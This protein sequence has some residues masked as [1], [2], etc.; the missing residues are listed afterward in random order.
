M[1]FGQGDLCSCFHKI[2]TGEKKKKK[3]TSAEVDGEVEFL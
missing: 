2:T 3:K 1:Y